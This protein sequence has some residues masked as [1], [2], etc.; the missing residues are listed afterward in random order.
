MHPLVCEF[1]KDERGSLLVRE[2]VFVATI[3]VLAILP[4]AASIR[5]RM[6]QGQI[7]ADL[8]SEVSAAFSYRIETGN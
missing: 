8:S 3:L 5:N 4:T 7:E 2:W 1:W 6:Q